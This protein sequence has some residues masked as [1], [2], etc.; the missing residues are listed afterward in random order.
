MKTVGYLFNYQGCMAGERGLYFD[1]IFASNGI[2]IEAENPLI[3]ARIPVAECEIR[4]LAPIK[5]KIAL[6]YGSIPQRFFDL[7]LNSFL[8]DPEKEHYV[9]VTGHYGYHLYIP[10]QEKE[11]GKVTYEVGGSVVLDMHSHGRMMAGFSDKDNKDEQ[12]LKLFGVVG[13]VNTIPVVKLR[14]GIYGYFMS[15]KWKDVFDGEL[16]GAVEFEREEVLDKD[17]LYGDDGRQSEAADNRPG[18]MWGHRWLRCRGT[19]QAPDR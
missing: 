1:Y 6:T 9:A 8:T 2:F 3:A 19:M 4:G 18:G 15:L 13:T 7:A 10:L 17:D 14:I 5:T 12:G 16:T 11:A